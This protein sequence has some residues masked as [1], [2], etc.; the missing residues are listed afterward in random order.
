MSGLHF[1]FPLLMLIFFVFPVIQSVFALRKVKK[2]AR[3]YGM[4]WH[5]YLDLSPQE[6]RALDDARSRKGRS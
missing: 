3:Q 2:I 1:Y 6:R 5:Q 4:S